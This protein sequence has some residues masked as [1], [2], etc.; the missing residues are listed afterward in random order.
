MGRILA[1]DYGRKRCGIAVTD[2]LQMI[3]NPLETV[4]TH[5]LL[6]WLS[7]YFR[8]EKVDEVVVGEPKQMNNSESESESFIRPFL[9]QFIKLFPETRLQRSDE[10]FTSLMASRTMLHAGLGRKDR[11]N[12]DMVDAISACIILQTYMESKNT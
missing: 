12:K 5:E 2:V 3:A 1:I 11:Q 6:V 7:E 9:K 4:P 8:K 10:R